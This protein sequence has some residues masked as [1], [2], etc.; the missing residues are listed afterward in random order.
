MCVLT[1]QEKQCLEI[2]GC[3]A[4]LSDR[5]QSSSQFDFDQQ[6]CMNFNMLW[7]IFHYISKFFLP[8]SK[9]AQVSQL[10]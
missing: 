9:G 5:V 7:I 8:L 1:L 4:K 10:T 6:Q 2:T 3:I